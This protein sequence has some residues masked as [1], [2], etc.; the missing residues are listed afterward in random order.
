[1]DEF[2]AKKDFLIS[3][4]DHKARILS[5]L[6]SKETPKV[7]IEFGGYLGYSAILFADAMRRA[8]KTTE[9]IHVWSLE[10]DPE[11]AAIARDMID[12]AG[13]TNGIT[14]VVGTAEET[15]KQ[16]KKDGKLDKVD[17]LFLDHAEELYVPDLKVCQSLELF[18]YGSVIVAD[19]VVRPGA[20]DY[21]ELVRNNP[22][23]KSEGVRGLIQPGDLEVSTSIVIL[24]A[25]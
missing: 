13:L 10:V 12:V 18:K 9:N 23:Y 15:L 5:N 16:L 1:M 22:A 25:R 4:G 21:R 17:L 6:I 7:A 3:I 24:L 19:N 2:S 14:V 20:P 11:F 8:N